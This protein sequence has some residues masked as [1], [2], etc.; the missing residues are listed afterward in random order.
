M[1]AVAVAAVL[2]ACSSDEH[3]NHGA[4]SGTPQSDASVSCRDDSRAQV[5]ASGLQAKST[6]GRFLAEIVN[7]SPAP[8]QRG[9]GDAGINSWTMKFALDGTEPT[10][11]SVTVTTFMPE[12]GHGS[13]RVPAVVANGD[14]TYSVSGLYFFMAGLW[15]ITFATSGPTP[16][17]ATFGFCV[18]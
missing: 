18:E 8:P 16:E 9:P 14:G 5:F 7:A 11:G 12:H 3:A 2:V 17:R 13:P 6:S 1:F 10:N 15:E 4:S